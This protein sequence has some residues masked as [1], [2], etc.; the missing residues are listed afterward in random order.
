[1]ERKLDYVIHRH[2][3]YMLYIYR[4]RDTHIY[5]LINIYMCIYNIIFICIYYIYYIYNIYK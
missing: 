4:E 5:I 1:M 2:M 3:L